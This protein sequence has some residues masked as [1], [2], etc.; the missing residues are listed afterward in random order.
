MATDSSAGP[1]VYAPA[2]KLGPVS[3]FDR[4]VDERFAAHLRDIPAADR[5]FYAASALGDHGLVWLMLAAVRGLRSDTSELHPTVRAMGAVGI[6]S[7]LVNGPIKWVFRR[8][9]PPPGAGSHLPLRQPRTSSFPSGHATSAFCAATLLS[10]GDPALRPLYYG[11]AV[12]VAWSRIHVRVHYAS[13]VIGGAVIGVALGQIIK[14]LV[15]L[16][17]TTPGESPSQPAG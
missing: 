4:W 3:T 15:P 6:E 8:Q 5:V 17:P 14:R 13:D 12:I 2:V 10:D 1:V 11:L 7:I 16:P 9:R